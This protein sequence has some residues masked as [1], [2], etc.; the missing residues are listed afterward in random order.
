V[1]LQWVS[2]GSS[3]GC[4]KEVPC[5]AYKEVP[6]GAY[7]EVLVCLIRR[8]H[9]V[10]I[11]RFHVGCLEEVPGCFEEPLLLFISPCLG[12]QKYVLWL[13]GEGQYGRAE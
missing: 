1:R 5:G 2:F 3:S 8:F 4:H 12:D 9:V 13:V 6:C 11:R 7:K 10:L